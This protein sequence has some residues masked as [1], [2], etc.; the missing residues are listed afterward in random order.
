MWLFIISSVTNYKKKKKKRNYLANAWRYVDFMARELLNVKSKSILT[1]RYHSRSSQDAKKMYFGKIRFDPRLSIHSSILKW[2]LPQTAFDPYQ[3]FFNQCLP[4]KINDTNTDNIM[5]QS[6]P[7][8]YV[9]K[10]IDNI[11]TING[12][13]E[14]NVNHRLNKARVTFEQLQSIWRRSQIL[15]Q[16]KHE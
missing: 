13:Q 6:Q 7:V 2:Q 15:K 1:A 11:K 10:Y 14:R 5:L 9:G 12:G 8:K 16:T 4:L 3:S